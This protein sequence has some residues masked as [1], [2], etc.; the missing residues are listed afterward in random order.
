MFKKIFLTLFAVL[1]ICT[2]CFAFEYKSIQDPV[3]QLDENITNE[4][5]LE[6]VHN[7]EKDLEQYLTGFH[8]NSNKSKLFLTFYK[9]LEYYTSLYHGF[10]WLIDDNGYNEYGEVKNGQEKIFTDND[11]DYKAKVENNKLVNTKATKPFV[12]SIVFKYNATDTYIGATI[13]NQHLLDIYGNYLNKETKEFLQLQASNDN[14]MG[15]H[16]Y[17]AVVTDFVDSSDFSYPNKTVLLK[18]WTSESEEFLNKYPNFPLKGSVKNYINSYKN[19]QD[20]DYTASITN[21]DNLTINKLLGYGLLLLVFSIVCVALVIIFRRFLM[22][23]YRAILLHFVAVI[24]AYCFIFVIPANLNFIIPLGICSILA[25][26]PIF[27]WIYKLFKYIK[28]KH[29]DFSLIFKILKGLATSLCVILLVGGV[30]FGI[31][32]G[33]KATSL[34]ACDSKFAENEVIEIFKQNNRTFKELDK[35]CMVSDIKMSMI[36]PESYN[37]DIK[38]YEC[39]ARLTLYPSNTIVTGIPRRIIPRNIADFNL[40]RDVRIGTVAQAFYN[41]AICDVNYSIYK[42]HGENQVTSS[43]CGSSLNYVGPLG[44]EEVMLERF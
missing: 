8:S 38:K 39:S 1:L 3:Q 19:S 31:F 29:F 43:Y 37:K 24:S 20:I 41:N 36:E 6:I 18:K 27:Y 14:D 23:H 34:P 15:I 7:T 9:N 17:N 10:W 13:D 5:L 12:H 33:I 2:N 22:K 4:A 35:W 16:L 25:I 42:E 11:V 21:E 30:G 44:L 32:K 28:M 26:S 40:N